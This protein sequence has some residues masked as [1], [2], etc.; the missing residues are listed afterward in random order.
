MIDAKIEIKESEQQI[1]RKITVAVRDHL[2][3]KF[4]RAINPIKKMVKKKLFDSLV[5][6]PEYNAIAAGNLRIELG[7]VD[8]EGRL[9]DII[10]QW[11]RDVEVKFKRFR[12]GN[13]GLTGGITITAVKS[14]Y[15]D[16]LGLS[17]AELI[18]DKGEELPWLQ[19]LLLEDTNIIIADYEV[20]FGLGRGRTGGGN[21]VPGGEWSIPSQ[22][23]GG[24]GDNFVTRA[25][26]I[27][28]PDLER[29]V[30][31]IIKGII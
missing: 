9:L 30:A 13:S 17:E 21:M 1:V 16:V 2:N 4:P 14:D 10:D 11:I 22:F 12:A 5:D 28:Q 19:W 18:T 29:E 23:A 25:I 26:E 3:E 8:G 31:D 7:L 15:F 27:I 6:S 20:K 24:Q